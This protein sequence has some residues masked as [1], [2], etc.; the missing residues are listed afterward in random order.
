M[1]VAIY[2]G[3][4]H[5]LLCCPILWSYHCYWWKS[6][7]LGCLSWR[8]HCR[9]CSKYCFTDCLLGKMVHGAIGGKRAWMLG[10]SRRERVWER[11]LQ[12]SRIMPWGLLSFPSTGERSGCLSQWGC[13]LGTAG[14]WALPHPSSCLRLQNPSSS[15]VL[16]FWSRKQAVCS[17]RKGSSWTSGL[18]GGG[19][20]EPSLLSLHP[21]LAGK[22]LLWCCLCA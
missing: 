9:C 20:E 5:V 3:I 7:N 2:T 13:L 19:V 18:P 14:W 12:W 1:H 6:A 22:R 21:C 4:V 15:G 10:C 8:C 16:H 17:V 11:G